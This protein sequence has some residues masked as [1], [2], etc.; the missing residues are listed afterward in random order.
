MN[1]D[2]TVLDLELAVA[3]YLRE[4]PQFF[5]EHPELLESLR[6][7]HACKPATS[8]LEYQNRLLR[9]RYQRVHAKL[10]ELVAIARDNDRLAERVQRLAL[11]LLDARGGLDA[12]L[13]GIKA[14]LRDEFKADCIT[15]CLAEPPTAGLS[16]VEEFLRPDVVGLF[17]DV[18]RIGRPQCGRLSAEQAAVLCSQDEASVASAALIPLGG[19]RW[20]GLLVVGSADAGR[21]HPGVGTLF[22]ERIGELV[23]QALQARLQASGWQGEADASPSARGG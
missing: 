18:F 21:F 20:R 15:L 4:H 23:S 22:L 9:E 6:I 2:S 17:D 13:H 14:I 3:A 19:H 8:L 7:P 10:L 12:L 5:I 1:E 11:N 16:A